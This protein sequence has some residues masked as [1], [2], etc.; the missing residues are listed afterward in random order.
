MLALLDDEIVFEDDEGGLGAG[1]FLIDLRL[2]SVFVSVV[3]SV[4]ARDDGFADSLL[5]KVLISEPVEDFEA[6]FL[7][8]APVLDNGGDWKLP[9]SE[10][11]MFMGDDGG[12]GAGPLRLRRGE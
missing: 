1:L 9:E 5:D 4:V 2:V 10:V 8:V 3:V 12:R 7:L 11:V 6:V